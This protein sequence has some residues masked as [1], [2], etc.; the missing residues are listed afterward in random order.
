MMPKE[1]RSRRLALG[2]SVDELGRE[3]RLRGSEVREIEV[4]ERPAPGS[5]V[6]EETFAR[7]E[8]ARRAE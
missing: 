5:M 2:L 7:L 4:D 3:V 1:I 8:E 6:F